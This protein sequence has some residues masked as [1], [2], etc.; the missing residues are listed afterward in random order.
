[1]RFLLRGFVLVVFGS[2]FAGPVFGH[3]GAQPFILVPA[4]HVNPGQPFEVFASDLGANADVMLSMRRDETLTPLATV[5]AD[6]Q[7]H[8]TTTVSLPADYP[9]GYA[10][11]IA[12]GDDGS[13]VST[14]VLVG[15]R[16]QSTPALPASAAWWSDPSVLVLVAFLVGALAVVG[17]LLLRPK[18]RRDVPVRSARAAPVKRR[19]GGSGT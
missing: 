2:I 14:W 7:G 5:D 16:A 4:D 15:P 18:P 1:M 11:L 19:R 12:A 17:Y 10:E 6:P 13:R 3:S 9:E 8:F